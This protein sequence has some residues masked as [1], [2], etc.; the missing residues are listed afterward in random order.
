MKVLN[1]TVMSTASLQMMTKE[2]KECMV[3]ITD[4][5]FLGAGVRAVVVVRQILDWQQPHRHVLVKR[6]QVLSVNSQLQQYN[7]R[8]P[9]CQCGSSFQSFVQMYVA[10]QIRSIVILGVGPLTVQYIIYDKNSPD[11]WLR[12]SVNRTLSTPL[13]LSRRVV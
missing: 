10:Y 4:E 13:P 1:S 2:L 12:G 9:L 7:I 5:F 8:T 3:V 6:L 11:D